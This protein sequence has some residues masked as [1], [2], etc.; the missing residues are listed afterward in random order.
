MSESDDQCLLAKAEA[1]HS[2]A[3]EWLRAGN[4]E[5][6]NAAFAKAREL[7]G[8]VQ[9]LPIGK[10]SVLA[11]I[12]EAESAGGLAATSQETLANT[13]QI[14]A[15][16]PL[17]SLPASQRR[18]ATAL[19]AHNRLAAY[20]EIFAVAM[21]A[22]DLGTARH[23]A[24]LWAAADPRGR[25]DIVRA[26]IAAGKPEEALAFARRIPNVVAR[27]HTELVLAQ[28]MLN[29]AGAPNI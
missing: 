10:V 5:R 3:A 7:A 22:H 29:R 2:I 6:A 11:S 1:F 20:Q 28:E 8:S 9:S 16:L 19:M 18:S 21:R 15:H 23:I 13:L 26:W 4:S 27:A 24:D 12:A 17:A 14:A 25:G